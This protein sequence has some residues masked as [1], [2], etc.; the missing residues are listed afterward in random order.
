MPSEIPKLLT[1]PACE[2]VSYCVE[3]SPSRLPPQDESQSPNPLSSF[4]FLFSVLLH[5][6]EIGLPF[7]ASEVIHQHSEDILWKL[8]HMQIDLLMYL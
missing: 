8:F 5:S 4:S 3:I 2:K 1:D 6:K 7:W